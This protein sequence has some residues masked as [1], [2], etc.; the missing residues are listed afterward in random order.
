LGPSPCIVRR[1]VTEPRADVSE[2][3]PTTYHVTFVEDGWV[4]TAE[5]ATRHT[6]KA[7]TKALTLD[8]ARRIARDS[9]PARVIVHA[10][11]GRIQYERR[12]GRWPLSDTPE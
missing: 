5:G 10:M 7:P 4:V 12:Y 2:M 11:D 6:A 3:K 9:K 8:M 1:E